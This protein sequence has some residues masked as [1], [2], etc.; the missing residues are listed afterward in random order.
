MDQPILDLLLSSEATLGADL[1]EH[2]VCLLEYGLR[3]I[4]FC[5][6]RKILVSKGLDLG[7]KSEAKLCQPQFGYLDVLVGN[8]LLERSLAGEL[9]RLEECGIECHTTSLNDILIIPD[10]PCT[11]AESQIGILEVVGL[12]ALPPHL[13]NSRLISLQFRILSQPNGHQL[14]NAGDIESLG[15]RN[16]SMKDKDE[17]Q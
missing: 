5:A 17:R 10:L 1:R 7:C 14:I 3:C 15:D 8:C 2:L 16:V 12:L 11:D 4:R 9:K 13:R 6:C